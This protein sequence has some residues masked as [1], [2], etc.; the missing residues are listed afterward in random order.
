M[1]WIGLKVAPV[2]TRLIALAQVSSPNASRRSGVFSTMRLA[3]L[4]M[5]EACGKV[6]AALMT[7]APSSGS[8]HSQYSRIPEASVDLAF[9]RATANS[10]EVK[11]RGR[12]S[13]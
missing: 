12:N 2:S 5:I 10:A 13:P 7:W 1:A 11:R 4:K 8:Q 3:V 6:V 9:L